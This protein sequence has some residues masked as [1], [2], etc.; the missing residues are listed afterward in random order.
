MKLKQ[1]TINELN[2]ILIKKYNKNLSKEELEKLAYSLVGYFDLIIKISKRD[3]V[4]KS[5]S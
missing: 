5:S 4:Q 1:S 2:L 3:T